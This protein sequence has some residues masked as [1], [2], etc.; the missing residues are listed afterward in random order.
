MSEEESSCI[1]PSRLLGISGADH[2]VKAIAGARRA[3][4]IGATL[5]ISA[6]T[7]TRQ[8]GACDFYMIY[9]I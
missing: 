3:D 7:L 9:I 8:V 2:S 5:L 4:P 6:K 1:A